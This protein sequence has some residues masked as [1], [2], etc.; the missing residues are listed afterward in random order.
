MGPYAAQ[1]MQQLDA[2]LLHNGSLGLLQAGRAGPVDNGRLVPGRGVG[3]QEGRAL[4]DR[5]QY[6]P[7]QRV[8]TSNSQGGGG[9]QGS[10][11]SSE[12]QQQQKMPRQQRQWQRQQQ[13]EEGAAA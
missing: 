6:L 13:L 7:E 12:L 10:S 3:M 8:C 11:Q 4:Q 2:A 1:H 9:V 5:W